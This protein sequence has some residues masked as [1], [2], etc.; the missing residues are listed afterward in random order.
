MDSD[1]RAWEGKECVTWLVPIVTRT[2]ESEM[3]G[4]QSEL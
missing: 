1:V 3:G 2:A 4:W